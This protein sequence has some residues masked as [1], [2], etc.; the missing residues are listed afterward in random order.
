MTRDDEGCMDREAWELP[1]LAEARE[2][3]GLRRALRLHMTLWGLPGMV[4]VAQICLS[5]LVTNVITHVGPETPTTL[6]VSMRDTYVRLEIRDPDS[7]AL[8]TLLRPEWEAES[9]RGMALIDAIADKWG[10]ILRE[11]HKVVWCELATALTAAHGHVG[12]SRVTQAEGYLS[13]YDTGKHPVAYHGSKL[14]VARAEEA[15]I[16][17]IADILHW[18]RAHGCDPEEAWDRAQLHFDAEMEELA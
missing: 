9:G 14:V 12:G 10:V 16:D 3:A 15:A 18:L 7:R 2:V 6:T 5:E 4:D 8:P 17:L 1:F 13:L 11:D